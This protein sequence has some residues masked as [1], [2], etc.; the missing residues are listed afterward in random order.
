MWFQMWI[1]DFYWI[2]QKPQQ[3]ETIYGLHKQKQSKKLKLIQNWMFCFGWSFTSLQLSY[4]VKLKIGLWKSADTI[5]TFTT[6]L[7]HS[8]AYEYNHVKF[9]IYE[10]FYEYIWN[11][12]LENG[13]WWK[14]VMTWSYS[15]M[16]SKNRNCNQ[17]GNI[18]NNGHRTEIW[19]RKSQINCC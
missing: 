15:E 13:K 3:K 4:I 19:N 14:K 12:V 18:L 9:Q 2:S 8:D 5:I 11:L 16:G 7:G 1:L 17:L 10:D 6:E